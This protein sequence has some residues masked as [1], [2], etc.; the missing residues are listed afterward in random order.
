M[1][2]TLLQMNTPLMK[3]APGV[4]QCSVYLRYLCG[5]SETDSPSQ[6]C[7]APAWPE[8]QQ[9]T[10]ELQ[11]RVSECLAQSGQPAGADILHNAMRIENI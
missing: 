2:V 5:V 11:I 6:V 8:P 9:K 1:N 4:W 10:G 3:Y 7:T